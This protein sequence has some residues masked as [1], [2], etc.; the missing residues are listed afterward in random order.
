MSLTAQQLEQY[1]KDGLLVV[2]DFLTEDE[3]FGL[4]NSCRN[5]ISEMDPDKHKGVFSMDLTKQRAFDKYF[6]DSGDKIRFFFE[7]A[8]FDSDGKLCMDKYKCVNKIGHGLHFLEPSFRSVS[9]SDK[10]KCVAKSL[11]F[12]EPA[13]VQGMYIF[14][15]AKIGI[16]VDPHQDSTYL[17]NDPIKLTGFWIPLDDAT[18]ENGCLW[19]V[20]GS[21]ITPVTKRFVRT[22][23]KDKLL[24]F[25]GEEKEFADDEWVPAPVKK[26]SLV[27]IHGQVVHKSENNESD[28]A[29]HA[30]T[31]NI[32]ETNGSSEYSTRNWLQPTE[33]T[34]FEK[35]RLFSG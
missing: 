34:P 19:Y 10:V 5:L 4:K 29:R 9:Y 7:A 14:K 13:I 28:L 30:Y 33:E 22:G 32:I 2:E 35:L 24:S 25:E 1:R 3:V 20:P 11:G 15:N 21:H 16:K 27:L 31:F 17:Y 6:L 12:T 26:G 23:Q 18:L 8:A